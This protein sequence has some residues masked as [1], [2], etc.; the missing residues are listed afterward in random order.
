MF[1]FIEDI[2]EADSDV[3]VCAANG[4]GWMGGWLGKYIKMAG[5]A[6]ALHYKTS[7]KIEKLS[8][9]EA[10]RIQVIPGDV[11]ITPCE[12]PLKA[13]Y[14]FHAVTMK[15]PGQRSDLQYITECIK[16]IIRL[17]HKNEL[18]SITIPLLGCGTGRLNEEDVLKIF[19][20]CFLESGTLEFIIA[21]PRLAKMNNNQ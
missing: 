7:G 13:K 11:F 17:A 21:N 9:Q 10:K 12:E 6:E 16:N 3:I 18:R 5:V 4:Q 20:S 2:C 8:M 19:Q 15:K 14:I 1:R